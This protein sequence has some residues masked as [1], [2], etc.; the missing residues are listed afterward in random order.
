M[1]GLKANLHYRWLPWLGN[2]TAAKQPAAGCRK[3]GGKGLRQR[4]VG[5]T[6]RGSAIAAVSDQFPVPLHWP[7]LADSFDTCLFW[8]R[9][10]GKGPPADGFSPGN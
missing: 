2:A 3:S 4:A 7:L 9:S 1:L 10:G 8:Q 5:G 6:F